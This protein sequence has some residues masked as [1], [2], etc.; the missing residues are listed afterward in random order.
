MRA[1]TPGHVNDIAGPDSDSDDSASVPKRA[2][3][4]DSTLGTPAARIV[5]G[6][7]GSALRLMQQRD[8]NSGASRARVVG[9]SNSPVPSTCQHSG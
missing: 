8:V 4:D 9:S 6:G 5:T 7:M 1:P 2:R 3:L